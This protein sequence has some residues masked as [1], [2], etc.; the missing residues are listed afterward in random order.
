MLPY[1]LALA[2]QAFRTALAYRAATIAGFLTNAFFGVLIASTYIALFRYRPH[3]AGYGVARMLAYVWFTQGLIM[4]VAL[5]GWWEI[6]LSIRSG[7]VVADLARPADYYLSWLCRDLG[8]AAHAVLFRW[9]PTLALGMLAYGIALPSLTV[10]PALA[11]SLLLAVVVSFAWR[12]LINISAFWLIDVRGAGMLALSLS[13]FLSGFLVPIAFFPGWLRT[14][15]AWLP[16]QAILTT[17]SNLYLGRIGG[18]D[19]LGALLGQAAWAVTMSLLC[20]GAL[21]RA[22]RRLEVQ[23]G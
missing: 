22:R 2:R 23:G 4:V 14:A 18:M 17:P 12:F 7:D 11:L 20:Y 8:R 5:W 3:V 10:A 21:A 1:Y 19:A 13:N 9:L 15:A 16:F 6:A